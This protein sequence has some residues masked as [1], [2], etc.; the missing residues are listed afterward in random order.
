MNKNKLHVNAVAFEWCIDSTEKQ[1][2][3]M[4]YGSCVQKIMDIV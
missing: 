2:E 3:R 4:I 1:N